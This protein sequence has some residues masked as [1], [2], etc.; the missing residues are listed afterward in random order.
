MLVIKGW[1]G[2]GV[3]DSAEGTVLCSWLTNK[4]NIGQEKVGQLLQFWYP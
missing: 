3:A 4:E 1:F 2:G